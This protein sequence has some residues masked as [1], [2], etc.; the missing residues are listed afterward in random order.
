VEVEVGKI[1]EAALMD[2]RS[3]FIACGFKRKRNP[4]KRTELN[5]ADQSTKNYFCTFA[6]LMKHKPA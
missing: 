6:G 4:F 5:R 1:K 2:K 3:H